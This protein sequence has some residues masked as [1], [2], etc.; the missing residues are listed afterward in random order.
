MNDLQ[1]YLTRI[2]ECASTEQIEGI[3]TLFSWEKNLRETGIENNIWTQARDNLI[4]DIA[5]RG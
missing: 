1:K 2:I 4:S 5:R 3:A